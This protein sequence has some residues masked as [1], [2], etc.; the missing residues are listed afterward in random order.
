MKKLLSAV[1]TLCLLS[2]TAMTTFASTPTTEDNFTARSSIVI[3]ETI[4]GTEFSEHAL[5]RS[6]ELGVCAS[7]VELD[8]KFLQKEWRAQG[9]CD[10][11]PVNPFDSITWDITLDVQLWKNGHKYTSVNGTSLQ[12]DSSRRET[13]WV[14]G[15]REGDFGAY[16]RCTVQDDNGVTIWNKTHSTGYPF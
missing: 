6:Y 5:A 1:L 14:E 2:T 3:S 15:E 9:H 4:S 8:K 10:I 11:T 13:K 7:W 12:T 16:V